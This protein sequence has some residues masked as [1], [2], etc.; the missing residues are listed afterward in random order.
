[1]TL[2]TVLGY[3]CALVL[4]PRLGVA[5]IW[6]TAGLTA[7]AGV[8]G[9]IEFAMLRASLNARIGATGLRASHVARL[10]T[11]GMAAAAAAWTARLLLPPLPPLVRG[12][13]LLP[14]FGVVYLGAAVGLGLAVPGLRRR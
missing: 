13:I 7:S 9:W 11:A 6:G 8:A 4:P 12:G 2:V 5:A 14:L 1:M 3:V 10:W